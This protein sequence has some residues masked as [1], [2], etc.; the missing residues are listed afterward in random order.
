MVSQISLYVRNTVLVLNFWG[1][2]EIREKKNNY[3]CN[4]Y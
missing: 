2:D 3:S 4:E 1:I